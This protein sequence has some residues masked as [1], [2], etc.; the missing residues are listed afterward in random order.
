LYQVLLANTLGENIRLEQER[1][2][3]H[4]FLEKL[5]DIKN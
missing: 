3:Y 2:A 1:I 4:Y 5:A